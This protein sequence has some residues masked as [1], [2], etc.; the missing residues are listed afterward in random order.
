MKFISCCFLNPGFLSTEDDV[1]SGNFGLKDETAVLKWI[2]THI[3]SFGG[4]PRNVTITGG[5]SGGIDVNL[6]LYSPLSKGNLKI[7]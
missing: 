3:Q 7:S 1:I 6:H 4:D 5:S 2:Q